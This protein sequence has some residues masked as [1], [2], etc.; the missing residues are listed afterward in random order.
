MKTKSHEKIRKNK[1]QK[2]NNDHNDNQAMGTVLV[3]GKWNHRKE[4]ESLIV[5]IFVLFTRKNPHNAD[6]LFSESKFFNQRNI[7]CFFFFLEIIQELSSLSNHHNNSSSGMVI[8]LM[9]LKMILEVFNTISKNRYLNFG[10]TCI[11]LMSRKL[12]HKCFFFFPF[13]RSIFKKINAKPEN[14]PVSGS[15]YTKIP[16]KSK[17]KREKLSQCWNI[18]SV[19][20]SNWT[21]YPEI[22]FMT[23]K[24]DFLDNHSC[25][26]KFLSQ[27]INSNK[28]RYLMMNR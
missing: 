13:H 21:D 20:H 12:L 7:S 17:L 4:W 25:I 23:M 16:E 11:S 5:K 15:E 3:R 1:S 14:T 26:R 28:N 8:L 10:R 27:L 2:K 19:I 6:F 24:T 18:E 9:G 22:S